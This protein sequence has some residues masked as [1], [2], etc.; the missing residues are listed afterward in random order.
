ME[1]E[2]MDMDAAAVVSETDAALSGHSS[3]EEDHDWLSKSAVASPRR[4]S[5]SPSRRRVLQR[6]DERGVAQSGKHHNR[7][8]GEDCDDND[9]QWQEEDSDE[10]DEVNEDVVADDLYCANM[11][12]ED[13]AWVYKHMRSG[14]EELAYIRTQ[15]S[16]AMAQ[17]DSCQGSASCHAHGPHEVISSDKSSSALPDQYKSAEQKKTMHQAL[18][19]KP[20]NSDAVLSCPRCFTTVC[21][22]CQQHESYANQYRAMFVMNIGVDWNKRMTYDDALGGLK[23]LSSEGDR[24]EHDGNEGEL[25]IP[26]TIPYDIDY[27][28]RTSGNDQ[29]EIYYAVHCGYCQWEVAALDMKDE[30]YYF[31]G[32]IASA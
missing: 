7:D 1:A 8:Y 23:L 4:R 5:T 26:D 24:F 9:D 29:K 19:L 21:M 25:N 13:E 18:L 20:R 28:G 30:I 3:E 16:S 10:D 17:H 22:D 27:G 6:V 11:D 15:R 12:D 31:F 2:D 32:C 14:K